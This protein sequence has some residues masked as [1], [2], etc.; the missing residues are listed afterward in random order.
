MEAPWN[1]IAK[2][3]ARMVVSPIHA[4]RG[5]MTDQQRSDVLAYVRLLEQ[6]GS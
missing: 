3:N 6:R 1:V 5:V 2:A 4:W